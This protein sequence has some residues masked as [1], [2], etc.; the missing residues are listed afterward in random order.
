VTM[1]LTVKNAGKGRSFETQANIANL[2]G[3][4][5]LLHA[6]R[7]DISNMMPGDVRKVAFSFDVLPSLA[8]NE[9]TLA[10]SVGDRDLRE[11]TSEKVKIP[12]Q[13]ALQINRAS[14]GAKA[15]PQGASLLASPD[16]GA[17]PFG[18]LNPGA[19]VAIL[20]QIGDLN[21]VDLGQ[22]RFAFVAARDVTPGTG[23]AGSVSF[24]DIYIRAP[25]TLDV[26]AAAMAT[27][28]DKVRV[29]GTASDAEK[30]MDVYIFVG[31]RKLYFKSN[32]DGAD[33]K[34]TAFEFDAPLRPGVN[35]I[36]VFARETPDTTSRRVLVVRKDASDGSI[37]KTP[38][39][40]DPVNDGA[41]DDGGD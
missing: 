22:G 20:G 17:R 24:E 14:G 30:L 40:D 10:L 5:L 29:T 4:G 11:S 26:R 35:L 6:G 25:P 36:T 34:K 1:H 33:P 7:F 32:R 21:K 41:V 39:T 38:K 28:D 15:G 9:A 27:K 8:D 3:D 18:R 23:S 13:P 19:T 37:L 12:L 16:P 31:S 2:S